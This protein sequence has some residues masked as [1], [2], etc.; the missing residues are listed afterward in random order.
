M[1]YDSEIIERA[2]KLRAE[3]R[4][5]TEIKRQLKL[6]VPKSTFVSWFK[7][8]KLPDNY[9]GKIRELNLRNLIKA[10]RFHIKRNRERRLK[11]LQEYYEKNISL[12]NKSSEV[13]YA[14]IGLA[15]L[16]LGEGSKKRGVFRIGSSDSRIIKLFLWFINRCYQFDISKVRCTLQC[17]ADQNIT[18]L[19]EYWKGITCIPKKLFYKARIDPRTIGKQ[20]KNK[21]Y[22]GVLRIDYFDVKIQ[23]EMATITNMLYNHISKGP[24]VYLVERLYGIQEAVGSTPIGSTLRPD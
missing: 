23:D 18:E 2:K 17:R 13:D 22:K 5:F 11:L 6:P 16:W 7:D 24:E 1:R 21:E 12:V 3:G 4:T 20:T 15:M 19:E 10:R 9:L 8:I 14:K